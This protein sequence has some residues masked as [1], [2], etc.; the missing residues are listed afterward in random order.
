MFRV[1]SKMAFDYEW[2]YL[3]TSEGSYIEQEVW[4][5]AASMTGDR[6]RQDRQDRAPTADRAADGR[7]RGD[8]RRRACWNARAQVAAEAIEHAS[9]PPVGAGREGPRA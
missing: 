7:L 8:S 2:K 3:A 4:R 9:A 6:A 1:Q 5:S